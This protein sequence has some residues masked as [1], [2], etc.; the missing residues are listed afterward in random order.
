MKTTLVSVLCLLF[1]L[2][3]SAQWKPAGERIKTQWAEQI[4]PENVLL[5]IS[6]SDYGTWGVEEFEW[7]VAICYH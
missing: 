1:S 3:V 4:S 6:T 5:R 7:F 2:G